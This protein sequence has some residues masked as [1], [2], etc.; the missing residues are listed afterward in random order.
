MK[1]INGGRFLFTT[2][3][4]LVEVLSWMHDC[5][6][7]GFALICNLSVIGVIWIVKVS[8]LDGVHTLNNVLT[9][10]IW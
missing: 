10:A 1:L 5:G 2:I 8:L 6:H 4:M 7:S 9:Y 3:H